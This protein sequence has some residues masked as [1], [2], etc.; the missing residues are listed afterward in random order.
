M[1]RTMI[2]GFALLPLLAA[3]SSY[4]AVES[5]I[6]RS[7]ATMNRAA[8]VPL[9]EDPGGHTPNFV[10]AL[11]L[12]PKAQKPMAD[13]FE[14]MIYQGSV[15][16]ELKLA[17]GLRIAQIYSS[18]YLALHTERRLRATERGR[19]VLA[20][21]GTTPISTSSKTAESL[22]IGYGEAL[23]KAV[24]G[25]TNDH[26]AA[27]RARYNDSQVVELTTT[28]CMFN[29][30]V[31]F[32][33]ALALPAES[34]ALQAEDASR[35][36]FHAPEARISLI[37]D[38]QMTAVENAQRQARENNTLGV[39]FANSMR[40][41]FL[42]PAG[43]TAWRNYGNATREY[44]SVDRP[45]K[46]HISFA[47][48]MVNGCRYCTVHQVVGL[49]RAGVDPNKLLAMKKDD[50]QLSPRELTAVEYARKLT[51]VPN[52]TTD[53]DY[54]K[55]KAVFGEQGALEVVMQTANFAYMNRFTDGLRL[56]SEDEGV[57][58]YQEIYGE[59]SYDQYRVKR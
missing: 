36:G 42:N 17:I 55:L 1:I 48:S 49:R 51:R 56:P 22:A 59:G 29:Y 13:L 14:T 37:S 28:T 34:W 45:L 31:R 4:P 32:V 40:A 43:A 50:A 2:A 16:P 15:E 57:K 25:V 44:A 41:M 26:F 23:T 33:E 12:T 21:L 11:S 53:A 27:V 20:L 18:P 8:R 39:G 58:I 38:A 5:L 46:L 54:Q 7:K 6:E 30:L 3:Q 19:E 35:S 47:V 52:S 10:R 9:A 24:L